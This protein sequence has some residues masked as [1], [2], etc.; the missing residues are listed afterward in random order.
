[1]KILQ[2]HD[3]LDKLIRTIKTPDIKVLTGIRR[4]GKS[5]LLELFIDYIKQNLPDANIIHINYNLFQFS[6]LK[7]APALNEYVE[8]LYS[9][10]KENFLLIDEVQLCKDFELAVN[11]FHA[12]EKYHIYLTGSNHF[13]FPMIWQHCLQ[14]ELFPLRY[15]HSVLKNL[16]RILN[17]RIFKMHSTNIQCKAEWQVRICMKQQKK[18]IIT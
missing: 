7:N 10:E 2:R 12:S 5:K 4:C 16:F 6:T 18:N 17:T 8:N 11:S 3:F 15:F 13:C 1:M 9:P 14:D